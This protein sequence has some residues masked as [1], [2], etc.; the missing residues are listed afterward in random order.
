M[1]LTN[2]KTK[3]L[4]RNFIQYPTIDSTQDEIWRKIDQKIP[5]GTIIMSEIQ[6]KGKGTHGRKWYTDQKG[7]IAFSIYIKTKCH[8]KKLDGITLKIAEIII[9]IIKE[10]YY[11]TLEIKKPNDI[12]FNNKKIGGILTESK[13]KGE[14]VECLVIGV[15]INT[16]QDIFHEDIKEIA[17]SIKNEFQIDIDTTEFISEFC[18]RFEKILDFKN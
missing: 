18:N 5:S 14:Q 7:N 2:L 15:G 10:K 12:V 11:I 6:T 8:I 1:Q 17:T 9:E 4:G 16:S 3:Y 13:I